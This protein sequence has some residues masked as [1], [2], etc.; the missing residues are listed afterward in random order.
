MAAHTTTGDPGTEGGE[1]TADT[2]GVQQQPVRSTSTTGGEIHADTNGMRSGARM[3]ES[4]ADYASG[5]ESRFLGGTS[6]LE[7]VWGTDSTG[8]NFETA[9]RKRIVAATDALKS[10]REGLAALPES[11][12][13]WA[14]SYAQAEEDNATVSDGL[15]RQ[16][17]TQSNQFYQPG[18]GA[19]L[20]V[21]TRQYARYERPTQTAG[22]AE[23][24]I[25]AHVR[26]DPDA[27]AG[28]GSGRRLVAME[29]PV[30]RLAAGGPAQTTGDGEGGIP[31]H[32][33]PDPDPEPR[34]GSGRHLETHMAARYV[35]PIQTPSQPLTPGDG[36]EYDWI[37]D[38]QTGEPLQVVRRVPVPEPTYGLGTA[39]V[40]GS[41]EGALPVEP[42][43]VQQPGVAEGVG[44][45]GGTSD[46]APE[47]IRNADGTVTMTDWITDPNTGELVEVLRHVPM[48]TPPEPLEDSSSGSSG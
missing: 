2:S 23:G 31:A 45:A 21:E 26:P 36:G 30:Y 4:S 47:P 48:Q 46:P 16:A 24:G 40:T 7:G 25:P 33:R 9:Y 18:T 8:K 10:I 44:V 34:S 11:V 38:P 20:P 19:Q 12:D 22:D 39:Q 28:S 42:A 17:Q 1:G 5:I 15:A 41:A 35:R 32:V 43:P 6:R 37:P 27:E 29:A 3:F 14:Q 13:G